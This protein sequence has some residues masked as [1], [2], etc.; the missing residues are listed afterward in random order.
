VTNWDPSHG[1]HVFLNTTPVGIAAHRDGPEVGRLSAW[2]NPFR[3]AVRLLIAARGSSDVRIVD[4]SGR[5]VRVL[6]VSRS[7]LPIPYSMS[8]D[9]HDEAGKPVAPGVYFTEVGSPALRLKLVR[10][11]QN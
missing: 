6:R 2:P 9:G 5:Q 3:T 8:W 7:P 4:A 11:S 10:V 1:N